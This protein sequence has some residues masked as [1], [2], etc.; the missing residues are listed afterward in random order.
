MP[1]RRAIAVLLI[2]ILAVVGLGATIYWRDRDKA[3]STAR[4]GRAYDRPTLQLAASNNVLPAVMAERLRIATETCDI[5]RMIRAGYGYLATAC[6]SNIVGG[7][8]WWGDMSPRQL[9]DVARA[10]I[11]AKR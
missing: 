2:I 5:F 8:P 9:R 3:G 7:N 10:L 4:T 1:G 6:R 11:L